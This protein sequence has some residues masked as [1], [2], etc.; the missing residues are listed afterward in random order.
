MENE[1]R[2]RTKLKSPRVD[3]QQDNGQHTTLPFLAT[4]MVLFL[5]TT[6]CNQKLDYHYPRPTNPPNVRALATRAMT[7]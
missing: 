4:P 1:D 5:I 7:G 3:E 6:Y 2:K